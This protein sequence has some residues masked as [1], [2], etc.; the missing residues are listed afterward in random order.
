MQGLFS[1]RGEEGIAPCCAK[2]RLGEGKKKGPGFFAAA[3]LNDK[4]RVNRERE[5]AMRVAHRHLLSSI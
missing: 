5:V 2:V 3:A 1:G 4:E